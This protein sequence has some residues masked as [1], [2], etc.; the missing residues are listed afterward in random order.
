MMRIPHTDIVYM[1]MVKVDTRGFKHTHAYTYT[2]TALA[3]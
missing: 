2:D 3:V 1:C